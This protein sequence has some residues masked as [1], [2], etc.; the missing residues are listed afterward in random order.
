MLAESLGAIETGA[1]ATALRGSRW[2]YAGVNAAHIL[3][4]ALLF[5]AILPLD[6][7]LLGLWRPVP[8]AALARV[9]VPVSGAGMVLAVTA[10][11]LLFATRAG[12][13]ADLAVFRIKMLVVLIGVANAL[14]VR[15]AMKRA[16]TAGGN[17][18]IPP[19]VRA[20]AL[21]SL[22]AWPAAILCGRLIAFF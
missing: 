21:L 7:R 5:G 18:V 14:L 2:G 11:A 17:A 4:I 9:L 15:P 13:Y 12:A 1:L 19:G 3:G 16:V 6:L 20:A 10:G 22:T 8:L